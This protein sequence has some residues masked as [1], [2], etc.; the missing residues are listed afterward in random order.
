MFTDYVY[1]Y[2][3]LVFYFILLDELDSYMYQSVGHHVIELYA[4]ALD[5]PLYRRE[6]IGTSKATD[7]DYTPTNDDE[8]E[9]LYELLNEIKASILWIV[10]MNITLFQVDF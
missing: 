5:L 9:D 3:Q 6:I 7:R 2:L 1:I 8:V 10:E 4:E